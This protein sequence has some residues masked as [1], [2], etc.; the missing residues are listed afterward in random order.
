[1][2]ATVLNGTLPL[3]PTSIRHREHATLRF[4]TAEPHPR[5]PPI[6]CVNPVPAPPIHLA[7]HPATLPRNN[8]FEAV[9]LSFSSRFR[10]LR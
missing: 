5:S 10:I 2:H 7:P 8:D 4:N 1:M 9:N 3:P 6:P